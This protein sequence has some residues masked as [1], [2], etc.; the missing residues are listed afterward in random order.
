[1]LFTSPLSGFNVMT[2]RW[3]LVY[4]DKKKKNHLME[5]LIKVT[6]KIH[7]FHDEPP[8]EAG[9]CNSSANPLVIITIIFF[10]YLTSYPCAEKYQHVSS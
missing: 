4:Y 6:T 7:Y 2:D 9:Q 3:I 5:G 8:L 1:M 10:F